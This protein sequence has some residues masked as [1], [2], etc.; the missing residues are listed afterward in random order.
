MKVGDRVKFVCP[1]DGPCTGVVESFDT[2]WNGLAYITWDDGTEE[3]GVFVEDL[4]AVS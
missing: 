4:E 2:I 3:T 1:V